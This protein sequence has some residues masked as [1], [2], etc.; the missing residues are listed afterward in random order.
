MIK[1]IIEIAEVKDGLHK[2]VNVALRTEREQ[3]TTIEDNLERRISPAWKKLFETPG[4]L[5]DSP[6]NT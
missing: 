2:S 5:G 4:L 6:A 1:L 3:N